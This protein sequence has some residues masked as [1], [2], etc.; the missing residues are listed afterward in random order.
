MKNIIKIIL[1]IILL[2]TLIFFYLIRYTY[3]K[4]GDDYLLFLNPFQ[5]DQKDFENNI[6]KAKQKLIDGDS[7][8]AKK[9]YRKALRFRGTHNERQRENIYS[10]ANCYWEYKLDKLLKY[11]DAYE[12]IGEI[13]SAISCLSPGLTSFEKWHYPIDKRFYFLTVIKNGK[14]STIS[15]LNKGLSKIQKLDCYHCCNYYYELNNYKIGIDEIEYELAKTDKK[16]LL[17]ELCD[18]YGL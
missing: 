6:K 3:I 4:S 11:S 15:K 12:F 7:I 16:V 14:H 1:G 13:D 8:E 5:I 2:G 9:Y 18:Q 17:K 10:D